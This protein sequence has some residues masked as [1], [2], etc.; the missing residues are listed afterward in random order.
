MEKTL[1]LT[2][3]AAEPAFSVTAS[4]V[5]FGCSVTPVVSFSV[6]SLSFCG[7]VAAAVWSAG[8]SVVLL[9]AMMNY[10]MLVWICEV[11]GV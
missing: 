8:F 10:G 2:A 9:S 11:E 5:D 1:S 6:A 7:S 3:E 4:V